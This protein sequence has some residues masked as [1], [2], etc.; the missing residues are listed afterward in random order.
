MNENEKYMREL[1]NLRREIN[2]IDD[3]IIELLD[4]RG[5]I[6][7]KI[8]NNKKLLD[9]DIYQPLREKEVIDRIKKKIT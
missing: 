4:K 5:E 1:E 9:L 7:F 8:G 3:K 2:T 6:A